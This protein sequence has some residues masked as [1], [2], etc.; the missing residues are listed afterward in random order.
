MRIIPCALAFCAVFALCIVSGFPSL[1]A[2]SDAGVFVKNLGD[3][4]IRVL[5]V[6]EISDSEREGR[7]RELL[8]EG[9]DVRRIGRFAL[10]RYARGVKKE[11]IDEYHGLFED[12]IVATY[13]A[14][15]AEYSGQ[16]FVIKR[17]AKPRKRGDSIVMSE[18]KPRDGGP[19]IRVDWQVHS[20][21][22]IYKIVD[23]RVEGVSMS[24]TQR[25]EFTTVIRSNGGKVDALIE[26]LRKKTQDLKSKQSSN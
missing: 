9:F 13:A 14:R 1:A 21:K 26:I 18:I 22:E 2:Q 20:N 4:A 5:T 15:F 10:G 24:I 6:K 8:R 7:F 11:S 17:V 16:Q 3:H 25:E 23:I 19:S 12:L